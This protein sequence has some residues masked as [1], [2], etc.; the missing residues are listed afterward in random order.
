[1]LPPINWKNKWFLSNPE[2]RCGVLVSQEKSTLEKEEGRV[3]SG[4]F[5][6]NWKPL[7]GGHPQLP[8]TRWLG[9]AMRRKVFGSVHA[10]PLHCL[11]TVTACSCPV[12]SGSSN[13]APSEG[14]I[15]SGQQRQ[16]SLLVWGVEE[17]R[18][19]LTS[20]PWEVLCLCFHL[21]TQGWGLCGSPQGD[22]SLSLEVGIAWQIQGDS[23]VLGLPLLL[24]LLA[25]TETGEPDSLPFPGPITARASDTLK[26]A[27]HSLHN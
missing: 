26:E 20:H 10:V 6:N 24:V 16:K 22:V 23:V 13:P 4:N 3:E 27:A 9:M 12:G 19:G 21:Q 7:Q 25:H 18:E 8:N 2:E 14:H 15:T 11:G 5:Q 1:M 17:I